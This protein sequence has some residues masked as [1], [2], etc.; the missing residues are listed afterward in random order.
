MFNVNIN[1]YLREWQCKALKN[2][3]RIHFLSFLRNHF[4]LERKKIKTNVK[5]FLSL[6]DSLS[7]MAIAYWA[8]KLLCANNSFTT[9]YIR[10]RRSRG[11]TY[12]QSHKTAVKCRA[13]SEIFEFTWNFR[14]FL[15]K[16]WIL[17]FQTHFGSIFPPGFIPFFN[18]IARVSKGNIINDV[19][20]PARCT[21]L[22]FTKMKC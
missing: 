16:Q 15:V 13:P 12:S 19:S 21:K 22:P 5:I 2:N 4:F 11:E 7:L 8:S 20:G 9:W 1:K 14:G 10:K 6:E 18:F 3:T 17:K